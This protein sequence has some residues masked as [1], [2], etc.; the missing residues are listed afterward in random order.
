MTRRV[1]MTT[2]FFP[3]VAGVGV[4]RTLNHVRYLPDSGW[5]AVVVGPGNSGYRLVE[6]ASIE[7]IPAG[8]EVHRAFAVEPA[9]LR[10]LARQA[11]G[12]VRGRAGAG[13]GADRADATTA[14]AMARPSRGFRA[15]LERGWQWTIP[16]TFFPDDQLLWAPAAA[17]VAFRVHRERPVQAIYSS[18]P[19][20]SSHLA[21]ALARSVTGLPWIAD[22]RDPWIG[23]AFAARLSPVHDRLQADLE[24]IIVTSADR[25]VFATRALQDLYARRYPAL[26]P[27]FRTISNGYDLEELAQVARSPRDGGGKP[28]RLVYT[29]SIYGDRELAILLD[30]VE[31]AVHAR[32]ALRD[33]LR[34]ELVGWLSEP[35]RRLAA[36]R[37]PSLDPIVQLTGPVPRTEALS[38]AA[39]ADAGL[40]L[41]ADGPDRNL[42]VGG[43]LF[44]YLG[45]D[46]PVLAVAPPGEARRVLEE[47]DWGLGVDPVPD[48]VADGLARI[49]ASDPP[50]READPERRLER[51]QLSAA[52]ASLLDEVVGEPPR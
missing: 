29:G 33:E 35:N 48:A 46:L 40:V 19:P 41:L 43:K 14:T 16:R 23:N 21:A 31:R 18:S 38:R 28:F 47:L 52:L 4:E 5:A 27:R 44:D 34:I 49:V 22:F 20:I 26:A 8:T 36:A 32:P 2:Y 17:W 42:F 30:G 1:L 13:A 10:G 6:P 15:L 45:L 50:Q 37:L 12:A 11:A 51:R 3:P 25:T 7:R 9:H 24:R 39:S